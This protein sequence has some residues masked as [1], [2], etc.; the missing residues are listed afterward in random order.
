MEIIIRKKHPQRFGQSQTHVN[1]H[2]QKPGEFQIIVS[3]ILLTYITNVQSLTWFV[4]ELIKIFDVAVMLIVDKSPL[5]WHTSL[6]VNG[7]Y[8]EK[9][10][11]QRWL[12]AFWRKDQN[13]RKVT[14][15]IFNWTN[16]KQFANFRGK[17]LFQAKIGQTYLIDKKTMSEMKKMKYF[18]FGYCKDAG[19]ARDRRK[20]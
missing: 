12:P 16:T 7:T 11:N 1:Y 15:T 13:T 9:N 19:R 5:K 8:N 10:T 20:A 3:M 2:Q 17:P 18:V 4:S 6:K 14:K